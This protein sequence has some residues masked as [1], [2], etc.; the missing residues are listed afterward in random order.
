MLCFALAF[1]VQFRN[2][3]R[4]NQ[5]STMAEPSSGTTLLVR[6]PEDRL[7]SWKEIA[8][9]LNRD[10]TTVQRWEKR[11][12]MPVHRHV[13]DKRG[14]VY[15]I[16]KELDEW[17][18][19]RKAPGIEMEAAPPEQRLQAASEVD[20]P[21][22]TRWTRLPL[23]LGAVFCVCLTAAYWIVARHRTAPVAE[24]RIHSLAVLPLR[25]L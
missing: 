5:E 25:N 2:S 23:T 14:S 15:A 21:V 1:G 3:R 20:E 4:L 11:E 13:H 16:P 6:P 12:G 22:T 9:Y 7:D 8:S 17:I 18:Q 10:I 24:N 19:S